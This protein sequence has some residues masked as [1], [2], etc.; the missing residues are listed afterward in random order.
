MVVYD[1]SRNQS[2]QQT[3]NLSLNGSNIEVVRLLGAHRVQNIYEVAYDF[4]ETNIIGYDNMLFVDIDAYNMTE[5]KINRNLT[6]IIE[7]APANQTIKL[8]AINSFH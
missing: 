7:G 5:L 1:T 6:L 2:S 8:R 4:N 3:Y